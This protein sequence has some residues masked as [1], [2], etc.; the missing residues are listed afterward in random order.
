MTDD[1]IS[2]RK[3]V[4]KKPLRDED[5]NL[6]EYIYR[7]LNEK[8][9]IRALVRCNEI[10]PEKANH[11]EALEKR[12]QK[13]K[14]RDEQQKSALQKEINELKHEFRGQITKLKKHWEGYFLIEYATDVR[15]RK[16]VTS[17]A[18]ENAFDEYEISDGFE[19]IQKAPTQATIGKQK[20]EKIFNVLRAAQPKDMSMLECLLDF[21]VFCRNKGYPLE[22]FDHQFDEHDKAIVD[23]VNYLNNSEET[24]NILKDNTLPP[25]AI[26]EQATT[27]TKTGLC[28]DLEHN[29][30]KIHE[31]VGDKELFIPFQLNRSLN[32]V[33]T[34]LDWKSGITSFVGRSDEIE[35]LH[36]WLDLPED[37]SIQL[38]YGEGGVGKTRLAF[39]FAD[40]EVSG[41]WSAGQTHADICGNWIIG[42]KGILLII[43]SPEERLH[44]V[45]AF[46]RSINET[47]QLSKK[48]R[49]LL[50]SRN[51]E[52]LETI[53]Q[54]A[55]SLHT[56]MPIHLS[57]LGLPNE[58][59]ELIEE[60]W[61]TLQSLKAKEFPDE[62]APD[63]PITPDD[64][65]KWLEKQ[66]LKNKEIESTPLMIIALAVYLFRENCPDKEALSK[67]TFPKIIRR[68][69]EYE[70]KRIEDEVTNAISAGKLLE[71]SDIEGLLLA[72]AM[73]AFTGSMDDDTYRQFV[74]DLKNYAKDGKLDYLPP[75]LS[76]I[77]K[78]SLR[79]N[80]HLSA[81]NPDILAE[82]FLS[83]CLGEL[84]EEQITAWVLA[85][86]GLS[87]A[88]ASTEV[89]DKDIIEKLLRLGSFIGE[90]N[91]RRQ[92]SDDRDL[93]D[94]TSIVRGLCLVIEGDKN[95]SKWV[96]DNF[97]D[98]CYRNALKPLTVSALKQSTMSSIMPIEKAALFRSASEVSYS[99]RNYDEG[100]ELMK[101]A[102]SI[103]KTI[104]KEDIRTFGST[105]VDYLE[106]HSALCFLAKD[107]SGEITSRIS[108]FETLEELYRLDSETY[109]PKLARSLNNF[110]VYLNANCIVG[111]RFVQRS[112]EILESLYEKNPSDHSDNL[113]ISLKNYARLLEKD[114]NDL[115]T[116]NV[117]KRLE[118]VCK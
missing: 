72:K 45:S 56:N 25:L 73:T 61:I 67:L 23:I 77:K 103:L 99:M 33:S 26:R 12:K 83:F 96:T 74:Y 69:S 53:V 10:R 9:R 78:L 8:G 27:S 47:Q 118:E 52:F 40:E 44:F 14:Y 43:D 71:Y 18:F 97:V 87:Q 86:T 100:S 105:L 16:E 58:E 42:N 48:L 75:E 5:S 55:P 79:E 11:L 70:K 80:K 110:A 116:H 51:R 76:K 35:K 101:Q 24:D 38:I 34:L 102:V 59:W 111:T 31:G 19:W 95:I 88:H 17:K 28:I 92:Y 106:R 98:L 94:P 93:F 114:G 89:D 62:P 84:P 107:F 109:G 64:L 6:L 4:Q 60:L 3:A 30:Y 66:E 15:D 22:A 65:T 29:V 68:M 91:Y 20:A 21:L 1:I 39:H 117:R 2:A 54:N 85:A 37:K 104:A 57:G 82:D 13:G 112:V 7:S 36:D 108:S 46:L 115:A 41:E 113:A 63:I 49:I 50:I 81:M 32:N 90:A